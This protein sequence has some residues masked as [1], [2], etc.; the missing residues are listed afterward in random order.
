MY[1]T[2]VAVVKK[3]NASKYTNIASLAGV[4][5]AAEGGSAGEKVILE[6]A[7]LAGG[8]KSVSAQTD[9][10]LEVLAGASEAAIVDMTLAKALIK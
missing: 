3:A 7:A 9:A 10:L 2:Q 4:S 6:N 1:N 8:L 5:I